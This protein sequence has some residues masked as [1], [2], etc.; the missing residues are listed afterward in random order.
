[1]D[2]N[3]KQIQTVMT[4]LREMSTGRIADAL[5]VS[6][7]NGG[8]M[9]IRPARGF[10]EAKVVGPAVTVQF[11]PPRPGDKIMTNY[12]VIR[13]AEPGSVLVIDGKG[14]DMHFTGDNQGGLR[15]KTGPGGHRC[16]RRSPGPW[17]V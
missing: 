15:Q 10:E 2:L 3:S 9:G 8:V 12:E 4:V 14:L 16:V 17:R 11:A 5:L 13:K 1:M 6:G 7:I